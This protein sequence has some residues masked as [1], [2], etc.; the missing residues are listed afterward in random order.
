MKA[1]TE[2]VQEMKDRIAMVR[3]IDQSLESVQTE[4]GGP[5]TSV[6]S[7][8]REALDRRGRGWLETEVRSLLACRLAA[9]AFRGIDRTTNRSIVDSDDE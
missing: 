1:L 5:T 3:Y 2:I 4:C 9:S 7:A 8:M 6:T